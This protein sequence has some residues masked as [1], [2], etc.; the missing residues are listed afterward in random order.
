MKMVSAPTYSEE[1]SC[2]THS[3]FLHQIQAGNEK[4]WQDFYRRYANM[5]RSIGAQRQLTPEECDDLMVEVMMIFWKKID[6]YLSA[7]QR[8]RFRDYV[9]RMTNLAAVKLF[10]SSH[11]KTAEPLND[12]DLLTYPEDIDSFYMAEWQ[13]FILSKA[14]EDLKTMVD[15]QTY[16][17][18]YMLVVQGRS[19][20]DVSAVTRKSHNNIYVIR[21]R[22][23][24]KLQSLIA[25]YRKCEEV[26]LSFHSQRNMQED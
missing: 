12:D 6:R 15:T 21:F 26:E 5:I 9:S 7:P 2:S 16:Q 23:L 17:V 3:S 8:G 25:D 14:L 13:D 1:L 19:V 22:C 11:K 20:E 18:F 4:A 10:R 24:K